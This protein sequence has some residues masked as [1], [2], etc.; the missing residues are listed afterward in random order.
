[1]TRYIEYRDTRN[2]AL[3]LTSSTGICSN[4]KSSSVISI[5]KNSVK[6]L[7]SESEGSCFKTH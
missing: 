1:M 6:T 7:L 3:N 5:R 2:R 4:K